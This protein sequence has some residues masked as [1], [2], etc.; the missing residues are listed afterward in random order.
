MANCATLKGMS[1][2]PPVA[3]AKL[4]YEL[5]CPVWACDGWVGS[6]YSSANR[7]RWLAE[8]SSVFGTVEGNSTFYG[9]PDAATFGRWAS[10]TAD[11]FRF[12]LKFPSSITHEREL[13]GA[14]E[15]TAE[16]V[17]RLRI[18][19]AADRLGP[20]L[21]QLPPYFAGRNLVD[22]QR[23]L[24]TLPNDLPLAVEVRHA[25]YFDQGPHERALD[26]LL[27]ERKIDRALFDT[28]ALFSA[29]ASDPAEEKSQARKPRSPFRTTVTSTRP[30]VRFVGR[31]HLPAV[32][33]WI[34]EWAS[35]VADWIR[36]G[37]HPYVFCHAPDDTFAPEFAE[38]FH[39]KL[40]EHL[41]DLPSLTAWPGR[42]APKQ[43]SLF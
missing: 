41:P 19:Q 9:V 18:L 13:V 1:H 29:P 21:I 16:F 20:S 10:D 15:Q 28:R 2:Q 30:M 37:L 8:Y 3:P 11:G 40:I 36:N 24:D 33:P 23:Y 17:D 32:D 39:A 26:K 27:A 7:R 5:G 35:I 31:N 43:Q 38:R 22:L 42:V 34:A 14:A 12:A 25:D 6:L 4:P